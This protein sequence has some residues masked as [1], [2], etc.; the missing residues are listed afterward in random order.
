[1]ESMEYTRI[2]IEAVAVAVIGF[3]MW[4]IETRL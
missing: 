2:I 1:M 3:M 4:Q